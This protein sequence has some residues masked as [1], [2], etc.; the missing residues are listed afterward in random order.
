MGSEEE[1]ETDGSGSEEDEADEETE[2]SDRVD[3]DDEGALSKRFRSILVD[4]RRI[5]PQFPRLTKKQFKLY[6]DALNV[7]L[8]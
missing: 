7:S 6:T 4:D 5:T 3:D 1:Q 8:T 2:L